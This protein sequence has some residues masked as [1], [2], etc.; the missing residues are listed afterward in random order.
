MD[1]INDIVKIIVAH[2]IIITWIVIGWLLVVFL[3]IKPLHDNPMWSEWVRGMG[4]V[5]L[6]G[7]WMIISVGVLYLVPGLAI[8]LVIAF[9]LFHRK[10][11]LDD[12]RK[13]PTATRPAVRTF[14]MLIFFALLWM[15][16]SLG[17]DPVFQLQRGVAQLTSN[18]VYGSAG[19]TC[20]HW[21]PCRCSSSYRAT[22]I[23]PSEPKQAIAG[24]DTSF[25]PFRFF[26]DADSSQTSKRKTAAR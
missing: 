13:G 20:K 5:A 1:L 26:G 21:L 25:W 22:G 7:L 6:G 3:I 8:L 14:V 12:K 2:K 4:E 18:T 16:A 15:S 24:A 11:W 10:R 9:G 19:K 17:G 23:R